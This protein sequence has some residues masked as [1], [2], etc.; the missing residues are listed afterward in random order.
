[1]CNSSRGVSGI[2]VV[3]AVTLACATN[4]NNKLPLRL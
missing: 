2:A 3:I 4:A 1:M